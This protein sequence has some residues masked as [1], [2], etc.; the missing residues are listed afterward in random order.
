MYWWLEDTLYKG[1]LR[2]L[3]HY[4]VLHGAAAERG[5]EAIVFLGESY[6][7]KSTLTMKLIQNGY[8]LLSD[9]VV[10]IDSDSFRVVPFPR[11]ILIREKSIQGNADLERLCEGRWHYEDE[12][13]EIKWMMDPGA[14]GAV[15]IAE[16]ARV[17]EI[18]WLERDKEA[19]DIEPVGMRAVVEMM[20]QHGLNLKKISQ[21]GVETIVQI[22]RASRNYHLRAPHA[23]VAWRI[24]RDH[25]GIKEKK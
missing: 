23:G 25:L 7:G 21:V 19:S 1:S 2:P 24:L 11:N 5:G 14:L 18:I 6:A 15:E 22:V 8:R 10:L 16:E 3:S 20:V 9:E 12:K 17:D 13:G 4:L